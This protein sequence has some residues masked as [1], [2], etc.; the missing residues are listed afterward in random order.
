MVKPLMATVTPA[1]VR[2]TMF[3]W[4]KVSAPRINGA[5]I[6]VLEVPEPFKA[7]VLVTVTCSVYVPGQT[8]IRLFGGAKLTAD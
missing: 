2:V 5:L 4:P 6:F 7:S 8:M 3:N 1:P